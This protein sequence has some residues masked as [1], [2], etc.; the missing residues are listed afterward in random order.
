MGKNK[1]SLNKNAKK[2]VQMSKL[3]KDTFLVGSGKDV[4][5]DLCKAVGVFDSSFVAGDSHRS[6]YNEGAKS[7][8]LRI[9]RTINM[10]IESYQN[11]FAEVQETEVFEN[12]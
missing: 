10:D 3:Y 7:S 2:V 5:A 12:E 8:I 11:L 6:A 1:Q 9:L 4:L